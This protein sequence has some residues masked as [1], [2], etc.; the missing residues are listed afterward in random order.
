MRG[1]D[2]L[3]SAEVHYIWHVIKNQ[4]WPTGS[5]LTDYLDSLTEVVLDPTSGVFISRYQG[6][7]Q[8][9]FMR[10]CGAWRG[11][12]G[13][14]WILVEY[15]VNF[16]HWVT[17]YQVEFQDVYHPRRSHVRWLTEPR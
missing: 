14:G 6:A 11:P 4:E 8:I 1:S 15:R 9:G 12:G 13:L 17:A 5:T 10:R 7:L 16:G 3:P 2:R